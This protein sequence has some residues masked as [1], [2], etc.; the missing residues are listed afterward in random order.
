MNNT[1]GSSRELAQSKLILLYTIE[2]TGIPVSNLQITRLMLENR[3]MNYFLL[4]QFLGEL[5]DSGFLTKSSEGGKTFYAITQSGK[6]TLEYFSNI[7]PEGIKNT[8]NNAV[9]STKKIIKNETQITADFIPESEN[10]YVVSLKV[11]EDN[12]LLIDLKVTVG[13]KND[14]RAICKSWGKYAHEIYPEIIQ[15]LLKNRDE[16][17][18]G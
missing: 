15:S 5:C 8:I 13:T 14:A 1:L 3:V 12:F 6:Q 18:P 16:G 2:K 9:N 4:Q 7:I 10:E 11:R 17:N